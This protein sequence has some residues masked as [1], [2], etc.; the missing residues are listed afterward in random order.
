[1]TQGTIALPVGAPI[2]NAEDA[3][4]DNMENLPLDHLVSVAAVSG[5]IALGE[6]ATHAICAQ[7]GTYTNK[8]KAYIDHG[9]KSIQT[10]PW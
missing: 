10:M 9:V 6:G 7:V 2:G 1:M 4:G 5:A 3:P 8:V